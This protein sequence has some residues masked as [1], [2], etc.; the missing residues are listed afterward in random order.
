MSRAKG[1]KGED[2]AVKILGSLG[3]Q[4][5][6]RN[7]LTKFGEIDIVAQKK[8]IIHCIEVKSSYG[9]YN[10]AENFHR[11]K[12]KRFLKTVQVYR[13]MNNLP[14]ERMQVDLALVDLK[15]RVFNL[16]EH[17]DSYFD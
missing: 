2:I 14:E 17:A 7:Y 16:V 13:Y 12:L 6:E 8:G 1:M 3:Y 10:P 11:T 15:N 9:P 5:M 4:I